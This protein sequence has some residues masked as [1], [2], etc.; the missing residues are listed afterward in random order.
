MKLLIKVFLNKY[1]MSYHQHMPE[2][3]SFWPGIKGRRSSRWQNRACHTTVCLCNG[4][5]VQKPPYHCFRHMS[6]KGKKMNQ[7]LPKKKK[8]GWSL[9]RHLTYTVIPEVFSFWL[10]IKGR[11]SSRWQNR[12]C[13]TT[14]SMQLTNSAKTT[15]PFRH[16]SEKERKNKKST[17][18]YKLPLPYT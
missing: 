18:F 3:F 1:F 13:H 17:F 16:M 5:T 4:Q 6:E 14:V 11:R 8:N 2:V 7:S 10:R 15:I 9:K 12:G